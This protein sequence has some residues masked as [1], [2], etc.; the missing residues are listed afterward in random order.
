MAENGDENDDV[1]FMSSVAAHER[2]PLP[3][4]VINLEEDDD[5]SSNSSYPLVRPV[6]VVLKPDI[7]SSL[8]VE[9]SVCLNEYETSGDRQC[10]ITQCGHAFCSL[11]LKKILRS[12]QKACPKCRSELIVKRKDKRAFITLYDMVS[13]SNNSVIEK[14]EHGLLEEALK[15]IKVILL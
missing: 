12:Q 3:C 6:P 2:V 14:L 15:R 10:A 5:K 11:C 4:D 9:C 7:S 1:I 8:N 13:V